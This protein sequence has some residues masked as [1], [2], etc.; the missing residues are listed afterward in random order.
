[1]INAS[2]FVDY[3]RQKGISFF[4]GV[5]DSLLKPFCTVVA[6]ERS[7][8]ICANEG[9]AV[10][11]AAGHFLSTGKTAVVYMQ[12]SGFGNATNPIL[13]LA[14]KEVYA[15]PMLLLIG[16]RGEP[17]K[18]DEP[19]HVAQGRLMESILA[20]LEIPYVVLTRENTDNWTELVDTA[21]AHAKT[22]PAALLCRADIFLE[23]EELV[24]H[25][26][27]LDLP[28][29]RE[30]AIKRIA[31]QLRPNDAVV[32]TTG[33]PSRELF[34]YRE[35]QSQ[36][37]AQDFLTVGSMGHAS[38]IALAI[39]H[40]LPA[41]D[42]VC[43]DGDGAVL[44][45]MGALAISGTSGLENFRHIVL[46]NGAHDSVG[47]QP[48]VAFDIDLCAVARACGYKLAISAVTEDEVDAALVQMKSCSG[49]TF[50]EVRVRKGARSDLGRP[51]KSPLQN[52]DDFI[53]FLKR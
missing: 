9:N 4:A 44:M 46:N 36:G 26:S 43:L 23:E 41:K 19:Q 28:L 45:H 14:A 6:R 39:A 8:Y 49:P 51:T 10:A 11:M 34:E 15:L 42:V 40:E 27:D 18:K 29:S 48:T 50:L 20:S 31:A 5:P 16:W 21:L 24:G 37:H 25:H 7:H 17:G 1:M 52:R 33:K 12:N 22:A 47:G 30:E 53:E 3:L 35:S 13:S 32:A 38:Q 2:E